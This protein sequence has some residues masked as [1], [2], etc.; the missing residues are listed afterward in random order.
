MNSNLSFN[1]LWRKKVTRIG[2]IM[3]PIIM[4]SM[5][6]PVIYLK[7]R[8][9]VF[10][11]WSI[12]MSSWATIAAAFGAYYFI[13]PLS[14]YPILGLTGTYMA[15]TSGSI[16]DVRVPAASVAQ[17]SVGVPY[18]SDKGSV[19]STIGIAGSLVFGT[20][21]IELFPE[22]LLNA[23]QSYTVPAVFAAVYVQ[24]CRFEPKL[25][26]IILITTVIYLLLA[27]IYGLM[28]IT[29]VI[30]PVLLSRLLYKKG[31]FGKQENINS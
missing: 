20:S 21:I 22:R 7:L 29:A 6:L 1:E 11:E 19:I 2:T 26:F 23:V 8:Y 4:V 9:G 3:I 10:P 12:A 31:F 27:H 17:D 13:E 24:F 5:F 16:S 28:M 14:Y 25:S 15:M 18:G 30:I